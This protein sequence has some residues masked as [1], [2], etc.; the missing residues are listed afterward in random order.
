MINNIVNNFNISTTSGRVI[1]DANGI[2]K[3]VE[4]RHLANASIITIEYVALS[5]GVL[6]ATN[7]GF[8][9]L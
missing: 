3:M 2:I 5:D 8:S 4:S 9:N 7:N 1:R 6:I